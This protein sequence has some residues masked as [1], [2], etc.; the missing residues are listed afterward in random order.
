MLSLV[1]MYRINT[2]AQFKNFWGVGARYGVNPVTGHDYFE[3][4]TEGYYY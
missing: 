2:Y 3:P 1:S 4:R